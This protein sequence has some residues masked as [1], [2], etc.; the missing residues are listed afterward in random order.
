MLDKL[1]RYLGRCALPNATLYLII[2]QVFVL[3][4]A[5]I[6]R[7]DVNLITLV[8]VAV[9][10][11]Q[12]WRVVTFLFIPP[13]PG[14]FGYLFVAFA[15]YMFYLMGNALEEYWGVFRYNAFLVVGWLLTAGVAFLTPGSVA[16]NAFLAGSVFLAFAWL[17]PDFEILLFFILPVKI[18][19]LALLTWVLYAVSLVTGSWATRFQ[20]LAAT[21]NFLLFFARDLWLTARHQRRQVTRRTQVAE[22]ER[23]GPEPR[24]TCL[25]CGKT[26]V[27][28]PQLDFRYCSKCAGDEC[29]CPEH[30]FAHAHVVAK[31]DGEAEKN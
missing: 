13:S 19:W 6:G 5:L 23:D 24:H 3:L 31:A 21:G 1:E 12:A 14:Y 18:K 4:M 28:H 7:L 10:D 16:S 15:W 11:G 22:R 27:T 30:I 29:Y 20:V 26:D 17:N 2:G 25:V 9:L 8:P